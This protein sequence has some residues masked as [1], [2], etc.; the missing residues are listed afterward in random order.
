M[1]RSLKQFQNDALGCGPNFYMDDSFQP[2]KMGAAY[3][4]YQQASAATKLKDIDGHPVHFGVTIVGRFALRE[5]DGT[6]IPSDPAFPSIDEIMRQNLTTMGEEPGRQGSILS[7]KDWSLLANDAWVLGGIH[8]RTEFHFASPLGWENLWATSAG[9]MTITARE[10]I[11]ILTSGYEIKR[12]YPNME[13]LAICRHATNANKASLL[14]LNKALL[15]YANSE[16]MQ[17]FYRRIPDL[18]KQYR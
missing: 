12:P 18:A 11:C 16:G 4:I 10:A 7:A 9:R 3:Q 13:A 14:S 15:E 2:Y 6:W 5:D 8:A 1:Y 17:T